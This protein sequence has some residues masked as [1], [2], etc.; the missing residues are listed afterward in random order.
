MPI[1]VSVILRFLFR[2]NKQLD[3]RKL[4]QKWPIVWCSIE[5]KILSCHPNKPEKKEKKSSSV[6][7]IE[8]FLL[9][10]STRLTASAYRPVFAFRLDTFLSKRDKIIDLKV[11][12]LLS[13]CA[14]GL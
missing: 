12:Y 11:V 10:L 2:L 14:K 9:T 4:R 7:R 1:P 3:L 5:D 8:V 6:G 13:A